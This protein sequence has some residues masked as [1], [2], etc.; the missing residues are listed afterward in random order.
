[1]QLYRRVVGSQRESQILGMASNLKGIF[2]ISAA[3]QRV[4]CRSLCKYKMLLNPRSPDG[5]SASALQVPQEETLEKYGS[6][7]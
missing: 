4:R 6:A 5:G 3:E 1:M 2:S 7:C